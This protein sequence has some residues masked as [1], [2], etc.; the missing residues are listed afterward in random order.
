VRGKFLAGAR[1]LNGKTNI[2][3][4]RSDRAPQNQKP[5]AEK[6]EPELNLVAVAKKTPVEE[7][8]E[9]NRPSQRK[10]QLKHKNIS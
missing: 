5:K 2:S 3:C 1:N 8:I 10:I 7:K 9:T 4:A 6:N